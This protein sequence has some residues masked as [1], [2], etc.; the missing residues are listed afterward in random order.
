M[1][2]V[3]TGKRGA[4]DRVGLAVQAGSSAATVADTTLA[5]PPDAILPISSHKAAHRVCDLCLAEAGPL[6]IRYRADRLFPKYHV[7]RD[8]RCDDGLL[9]LVI[10]GKGFLRMQTM[11]DMEAKA[12]EDARGALWNGCVAALGEERAMAVFGEISPQ[13]VDKI[14]EGI[15][16]AV[17]ISMRIQSARGAMPAPLGD[18]ALDDR[19]PF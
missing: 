11:T 18:A 12:I 15:W 2:G 1:R 14:I 19:I 17:R 5:I 9:T 13:H 6:G 8:D 7:C 10:A 3:R 16:D 4:A